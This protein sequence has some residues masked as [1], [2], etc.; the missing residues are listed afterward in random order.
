MQTV[1]VIGVHTPWNYSLSQ[2]HKCPHNCHCACHLGHTNEGKSGWK[3]KGHMP[4]LT[5]PT[6]Q[7]KQ[8]PFAELQMKIGLKG[9]ASVTQSSINSSGSSGEA[10]QRDF[11]ETQI[12]HYY[13]MKM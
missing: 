11:N 5:F 6:K 2:K 12:D 1:L 10:Y 8:F 3:Q 13:K 4:V 7:L 9:N